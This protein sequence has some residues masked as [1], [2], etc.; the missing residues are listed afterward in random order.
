MSKPILAS[1]LAV[2]TLCACDK[3]NDPEPSRNWAALV[4]WDQASGDFLVDG[5]PAAVV[6]A[7]DFAKGPVEVQTPNAVSRHVA[8]EGLDVSSVAPDARLRIPL[9]LRGSEASLVVVRLTRVK[10]G[11]GWDGALYYVTRRHGEAPA[12]M[13]F[14]GDPAAPLAGVPVV[15]VYDMKDLPAG[16]GDWMRS[17]I[18]HVRLDLD[19]EAGGEVVIHQIAL[20]REP[21]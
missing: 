12:F 11:A 9:N 14:P 13:S 6:K 3:P 20:V 17:M 10:A 8:G 7:W 2:L 16:G 5:R 1:L 21:I 18:E 19:K 15:L 4:A